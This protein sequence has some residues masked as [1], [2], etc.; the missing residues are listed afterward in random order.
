MPGLAVDLD[1][2]AV[3]LDDA[4]A[5]REA[6]PGSFPGGLGGEEWLE[7][8]VLDLRRD[9]WPRVTHLE[10]H[11]TMRGIVARRDRDAAR[12]RAPAH[13]LVRVC[14]EVHEHLIELVWIGPEPR[15]ALLEVERELHVGRPELV[16]EKLDR[17]FDDCLQ[18]HVASLRHTLT[19]E[20]EKV[21]AIRITT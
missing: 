17:L 21:A 14:Q 5:K 18:P 2:S 19:G 6:E 8:L 3:L 10:S 11:A 20:G 13:G 12:A 9:A 7:D 15:Q 4:A 1:R 16:G